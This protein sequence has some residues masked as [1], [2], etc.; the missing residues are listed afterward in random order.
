[1]AVVPI[2]LAPGRRDFTIVLEIGERIVPVTGPSDLFAGE[3]SAVLEPTLANHRLQAGFAKISAEGKI[4]L[5]CADENDIPLAVFQGFSNSNSNRVT[6]GA[7]PVHQP[8]VVR[9]F[10]YHD[11]SSR[12]NRACQVGPSQPKRMRAI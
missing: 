10:R 9:I 6:N 12:V 5:P 2:E 1:M 11:F 4:I 8:V 7:S 3:P